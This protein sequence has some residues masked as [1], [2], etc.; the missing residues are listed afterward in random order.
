MPMPP[1]DGRAAPPPPAFRLAAVGCGV[2]AAVVVGIVAARMAGID[3]GRGVERVRRLGKPAPTLAPSGYLTADPIRGHRHVP[4]AV[5]HLRTDEFDATYTIDARGARDMPAHRD[6][7]TDRPVIEIF[8]DSFTFGHGVDAGVRYTD[9]LATT[10]GCEVLNLG[11]NAYAP[12]QELLYYENEGRRYGADVVVHQLYLGND[13]DD[14]GC[15]RLSGWPKPWFRLLDGAAGAEPRLELVPPRRSW[16]VLLRSTSYLAEIALQAFDR[17]GDARTYVPEW[18]GRDLVPLLLAI[19]RRFAADV[20]KDGGRFLVLI[21]HGCDANLRQVRV[22]RF[23]VTLAGL[24]AAGI[25][26]FDTFDAVAASA[27]SGPTHVADG[28]WSA[29][30]HAAVAAALLRELGQAG[31]L[32]H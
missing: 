15:E 2:I 10:C 24:V 16:G 26:T 3:L 31:W 1:D 19:E 25:A 28:H 30:G 6:A 14:L 17:P 7:P 22:D 27:A 21:A 20:A 9:V 13:L 29:H 11:V 18:Q 5:G 8:G 23:A 4:G 32:A 12:D